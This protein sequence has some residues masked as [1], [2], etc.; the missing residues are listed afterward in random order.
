MVR[1][2]KGFFMCSLVRCFVVVVGFLALGCAQEGTST[3]GPH[4]GPGDVPDSGVDTIPGVALDVQPVVVPLDGAVMLGHDGGGVVP[5]DTSPVLGLDAIAVV[6]DTSP[7][8]DTAPAIPCDKLGPFGGPTNIALPTTAYCFKLC[9][10]DFEPVDPMSYAW[11]CYGFTDAE[12]PITVNGQSVSCVG[13]PSRGSG[14]TLPPG[15]DGAWT[16][17]LPAGGHVNDF[18]KWVGALR[19]CP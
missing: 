10:A 4:R 6:P 8:P 1:C 2:G 16:F 18:I 11:A 14:S 13:T 7:P 5:P 12:R 19:A 9:S 3:V 17:M 15:V